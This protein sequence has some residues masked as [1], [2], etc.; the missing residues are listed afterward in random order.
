MDD[1]EKLKDYVESMHGCTAILRSVE[2][3][4]EAFKGEIVWE[5]I[6]HVFNIKGNG[7]A[8]ICYAWSSP[9]GDS[10]QRRVYAV[11]GKSPINTPG[12]AVRASIVS[13]YR[14]AN[15]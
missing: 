7:I 15:P 8:D 10:E 13:D 4:I 1:P 3:V 2:T 11:L 12:D 14:K 9:I 5:G 6:L